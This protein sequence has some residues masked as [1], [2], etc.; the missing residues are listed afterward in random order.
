M[1]RVLRNRS[2]HLARA[3]RKGA[4]MK[5][6]L[7]VRAGSERAAIEAGRTALSAYVAG[8]TSVVDLLRLGVDSPAKLVDINP[9]SGVGWTNIE[10]RSGEMHI[11][12]LARNTDVAYHPLIQSQFPALSQALLSGASPQLRNMASMGGNILQRT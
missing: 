11:G 5:P 12:A 2:R 1:R 7:Y 3:K 4:G 8:G 6:F 10:Q 9:L